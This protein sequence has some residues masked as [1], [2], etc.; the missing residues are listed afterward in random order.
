M[1]ACATGAR[2]CPSVMPWRGVWLDA[3]R[4]AR[5]GGAEALRG[6]WRLAAGRARNN[7]ARVS[8]HQRRAASGQRAASRRASSPQRVSAP[9]RGVACAGQP[10]CGAG[11]TGH[12]LAPASRPPGLPGRSPQCCTCF[13]AR[14]RACRAG[15]KTARARPR[16]HPALV[17]RRSGRLLRSA[18]VPAAVVG[19]IAQASEFRR[20]VWRGWSADG[21]I[22]LAHGHRWR[23][24]QHGCVR[25]MRAGPYAQSAPLAQQLAVPLPLA[26]IVRRLARRRS[27][28]A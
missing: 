25:V 24:E 6:G 21:P 3:E 20:D 5:H 19:A 13:V 4:R 14:G 8:A 27:P 11:A 12:V 10:A 16:T 17:A 26:R 9:Y 7:H 2:Q 22:R 28:S 18:R 1:G 15:P 23:V